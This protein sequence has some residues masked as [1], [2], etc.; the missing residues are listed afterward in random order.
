[1]Y[2][3]ID[4]GTYHPHLEDCYFC[5]SKWTEDNE[6]MGWFEHYICA[7]CAEERSIDA[8]PIKTKPT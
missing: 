6:P 2:D 7:D 1:M 5:H 8:R 3:Y 4:S